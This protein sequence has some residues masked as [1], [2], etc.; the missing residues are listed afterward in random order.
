MRKKDQRTLDAL[1]AKR[2]DGSIEWKAVEA[3]FRG[4]GA[5]IAEKKGSGIDVTLNHIDAVFHR[6]HPRR[7]CGRSLVKRVREF[8]AR[9][10][11][12]HD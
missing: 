9:A 3:L 7:E 12:E 5:D 10:G 2:I 1:F 11:V 8:L 6:P 4:L